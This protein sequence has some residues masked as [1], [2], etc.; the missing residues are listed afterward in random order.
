[1]ENNKTNN[2]M[3]LGT[4]L[5]LLGAAFW[6]L[7]AVV[8]KYLMSR[9]I[10]TMWMVNFRM[11]S[12]G[13]ILLLIAAIRSPKTLFNIWKDR[14]SVLRLLIISIFAFG[15]CQLTY[16]MSI[17]YC[18]AG[19]ATAIQQTAPIFVLL[20]VV[21]K[22]H[23]L[24]R[25]YEVSVLALVIFGSFMIATAGDFGALAIE[26]LALIFGLI[27]ALTCALY[28]TLPAKLINQYGTFETVGWGLFLG[29][30]FLVPFCKLWSFPALFDTG[31]ILGLTYIILLGAVA[32]FALYLYGT[33]I[34]GPVKAGVFGLFEPVVA[35][36]AS[37]VFLKQTFSVADYVGIASIL[38]GITILTLF[39]R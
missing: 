20:F 37:A 26:P 35:T 15:V 9:G 34:V 16:F 29:G 39:K 14:S 8:G 31:I 4:A 22:E 27:S 21:I 2:R 36:F 13:A 5:T 1:M 38:L 24:P 32:A 17:Q 19:I 11:I 33:T 6:G 7:C 25:L 23:R 18:N 28:I 10:D 30:V 12:S 3:I